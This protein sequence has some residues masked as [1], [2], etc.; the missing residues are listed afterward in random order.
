MVLI[1]NILNL[2]G[3]LQLK[4]KDRDVFEIRD[5]VVFWI[6][7]CQLGLNFQFRNNPTSY[8]KLLDSM[9]AKC[10]FESSRHTKPISYFE[11]Y[12]AQV[13]F[14]GGFLILEKPGSFCPFSG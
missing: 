2:C 7:S 8:S 4:E 10:S 13:R 6:D 5:F 14:S 1:P 9:F 11:G 3:Q 12:L